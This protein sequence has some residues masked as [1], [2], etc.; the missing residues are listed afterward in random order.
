MTTATIDSGR[1]TRRLLLLGFGGLLILLAFTGLNALSVLK[2]IQ[3]RNEKI[4][5]DY[6]H[7][8]RILEQ[9]R[10]DLYLSGTYARDLL[11]ETDPSR[12]DLH[13][14]ELE[15]ARQRVQAM[16]AA[17]QPI[18]RPDERER[19][20]HLSKE[21][22]SFF[23]MLQPVLQWDASQRRQLGYNF[24]RDY[25]LPQRMLIVQLADQISQLN[26]QQLEIG[27]RQLAELFSNFRQ[28]LRL[29]LAATL[30][31]GLAL[32]G[33][34]IYRI[35]RL[36]KLSEE[37]FREVVEAR[38]ELRTLSDRLV[39][40]QETE[41]RAIARELHDEVGQAVSA[42]SLAVGN[43]A[44]RIGVETIEDSK[45]ELRTIRQ[46]AEK[47]VAA[48]RDISLLLRPSML[49]DLGLIPALEWQA[50]EVSRNHNL[51]VTVRADSVPEEIAEEQKTCIYR[52]VQE[53]LR[54]V[55]RHAQAKHVEIELAKNGSFLH[56]RIR[57]DGHGFSPDREKGM[58]LL[59]MQER[60]RRLHGSFHV[61]SGPGRGTAVTVDLPAAAA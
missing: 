33:G 22:T 17:Y 6:V 8:D 5:E 36:E 48:V 39:E 4:R 3:K 60:V 13:R 45:A 10:A 50:R 44:A 54:N 27:N 19:F 53:A 20:E 55:T 49:D 12:A 26:Q 14:K 16:I 11:L 24:M 28:G 1:Q 35:L 30:A 31:I 46:I 7:R 41:R 38:T 15:S 43:V 47:T 42:V 59:G 9:L 25:L 2:T 32:A 40:A 52:V 34:S 37:R 23:Q 58:G 29:M 56:L 57:D 61:D 21:V 51:R 18:L